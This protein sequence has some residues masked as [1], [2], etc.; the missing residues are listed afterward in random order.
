MTRT[1]SS[2]LVGRQNTLVQLQQALHAASRGIGDCI[3]VEGPAGIGKSRILETAC[4]D[5][6]EL[7]MAVASGMATEIDRAAPLST[8]VTALQNSQAPGLDV[9][10]LAVVGGNPL[11]L[12]DRLGEVIEEGVRTGPLLVTLDD[13]HWADELTA[14]A[15]RLLVPALS[16]SP[17]LWLLARRPAPARRSAQD[18]IEW[19][20]GQGARRLPVGPLSDDAVEQLCS[21]LLGASPDR[22]VLAQAARSGGNPFLLEELLSALR[23]AGQVVVDEGVASLATDRLPPVFLDAVRQRLH[24][25]SEEAR[26]VLRAGSVLGRPFTVHEAAGLVGQSAIDLIPAATE[27]VAVGALVDNGAELVFRH[28]LIREAVYNG[29]SGPVRLALHREASSVVHA[30]GGSPMEVAEH[31]I[32]GGGVGDERAVTVLRDAVDQ[33]APTAPGTA[34]D[35]I[36]RMLDLL[37]EHDTARPRLVA[38][39]VHLLASAGRVV[40]ARELGENALHAGLDAPAE[41]DLLLGLS[42]ALKHAGHNRAVVRYT[43]TALSRPDVPDPAR[44]KL[45]AI[46]SHAL[47]RTDELAD[48]DRAGAEAARIARGCG[49]HPPLVFATAARSYVARARGQLD[50]GLAFA[51][52]AVRDADTAGGRAR[53][54]HPRLWLAPALAALDRFTEADAAFEVG[55]REA[56]ELG[57]AWSQPLWHHYRAELRMA[58]GRLDDAEA[59]AEAGVRVAEQLDALALDVPLL[60][61]LGQVALLRDDLPTARRHLNRARRLVADGISVG[62]EDL[63]WRVALLLDSTDEPESA[64]H[65]LSGV[66][67]RLPERVYLLTQ[68]PRAAARLVRIAQRGGAP[69]QAE[70]VVAAARALAERNP[71]VTS[72]VGAARHAEGVLRKDVG[73]LRNAVDAYRASPRP[74]DRAAARE[75][76]ALAEN[77]AGRRQEAISLLGEAIDEYTASGSRR[78]A[79][80]AHRALRGLGG[81]RKAQRSKEKRT[82]W[83]DLTESE[84][85]VVR[86]VAEGLT[87]RQ[88]ASRLFLSPHTV[89]SHLRHSFTKLGVNSRVE[90]TRMVMAHLAGAEHPVKT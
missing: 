38:D 83:G 35:L 81:R 22:T 4:S 48:A 9:A 53:H 62:P 8:L 24:D 84:M 15:L 67:G 45:M 1:R 40:E 77:A 18:A 50:E 41:A 34:A 56:D 14:L 43:R 20:I 72:L 27:A 12:V 90:L 54:R 7:G 70:T 78:D 55:Q 73:A 71:E 30:E 6:S 59:E 2:T 23:D 60:A 21:D 3:V 80:R 87:N 28:D 11:W 10:D 68:E 64:L 58:A 29:L 26:R 85:R 47:L 89:D 76:A 86:L 79:A 16:S 32:R 33:V 17:V 5:A 36:L 25:L 82:A 19:L 49:E 51:Q 74:L 75:D 57:T 63:A 31:L 69:R 46:Q 66:Y 61:L 37:D 44:A 13:A 42:E 88:V 65:T 52:Q 39:A